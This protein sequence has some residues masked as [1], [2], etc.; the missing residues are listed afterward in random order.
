[1]NKEQLLILE[2]L[3]TSD[4]RDLPHRRISLVVQDLCRIGGPPWYRSSL[5]ASH[6]YMHTVCALW[7][8]T[9]LSAHIWLFPAARG[10]KGLRNR[11][12]KKL[13]RSTKAGSVDV[14][15]NG[16]TG[17]LPPST[18]VGPYTHTYTHTHILHTLTYPTHAHTHVPHTCTHSHTPHMYT[19]TYPTHVHTH[20]LK[21]NMPEVDE[22]GYSIRPEDAA[23]ISQFPD[24]PRERRE[25][26]D[27]D[28]DTD[29][30]EGEPPDV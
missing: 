1:M 17:T 6:K 9:H 22:E 7:Y 29:S 27:S 15:A 12:K 25:H 23:N 19:L 10:E 2:D 18:E 4:S 5:V 28:T 26:R 24:D 11:F 14:G 20:T 3:L 16:P 13:G 8:R 30:E 21:Q